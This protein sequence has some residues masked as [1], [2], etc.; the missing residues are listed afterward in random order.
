MLSADAKTDAPSSDQR[1][2]KI[3][4][5]GEQECCALGTLRHVYPLALTPPT[6]S[7]EAGELSGVPHMDA[8]P[9]QSATPKHTGI[10]YHAA[11]RAK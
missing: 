4:M 8:N 6:L 11:V 2:P 3:G 10:E 9:N 1:S 5:R 7:P